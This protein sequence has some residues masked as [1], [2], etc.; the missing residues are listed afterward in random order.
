MTHPLAATKDLT[1][2]PLSLRRRLQRSTTSTLEL[3]TRHSGAPLTLALDDFDRGVLVTGPTGTGKTRLL[4]RINLQLAEKAADFAQVIICPKGSYAA[5]LR[6][7][8]YRRGWRRRVTFVS[9]GER[10]RIAGLHLLQR[11]GNDELQ[12]KS[13][14]DTLMRAM[15]ASDLSLMPT[16]A[17]WSFAA[18]YGAVAAGLTMAEAGAL[19]EIEDGGIRRAVLGRLRDCVARRDL[20]VL[21]RMAGHFERGGPSGAAAVYRFFDDQV[22]S[23]LRRLRTLQEN[24]LLYRMLGTERALSWDRQLRPGHTTIIDANLGEALDEEDQRHLVAGL[25]ANLKQLCFTRPLHRRVRVVLTIDEVGRFPSDA[26]R[27][28]NDMGREHGLTVLG[29]HQFLGQFD[30]PTNSDRRL[31]ESFLNDTGIKIIFGG[32]APQ[33]AR[34]LA[35][36]AFE[37]H[38]DPDHRQLELRTQRQLSR[39][40]ASSSETHGVSRSTTHS[41]IEAHTEADGDSTSESDASGETESESE[42]ALHVEGHV[43]SAGASESHAEAISYQQGLQGAIEVVRGEAASRA[44]S[45]SASDAHSWS[46]SRGHSDSHTDSSSTSHVEADT[47]ARSVAHTR[48]A[49]RSVTRSQMVVPT[50]VFEELSSV[51]FEPLPTQLHRHTAALIGQPK[52]HA[53][54]VLGKEPPIAFRVADVPDPAFT[55]RQAL[56]LDIDMWNDHPGVFS[57]ASEIDDEIQE[58]QRLLLEEVAGEDVVPLPSRAEFEARIG[59]RTA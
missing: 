23:T 19:V 43:V 22:G 38:L 20:A 12:A 29:A 31:R 3:G 40:V 59:R 28:I 5:D 13:A 9:V 14:R 50:E 47:Y 37:H 42:G 25:V 35:A 17:R 44:L 32:L 46:R 41:V 39:V 56:L 16:L 30:N 26:L 1:P 24:P 4:R 6:R 18:L 21:E 53:Y 27:E 11:W 52:Q 54:F 33:D 55:E 48:G 2:M 10:R 34:E 36:L 57:T 58:R 15:G 7:D 45:D 8:F 49:T 51:Q